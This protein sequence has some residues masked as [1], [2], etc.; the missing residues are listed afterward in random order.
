MAFG[1]KSVFNWIQKGPLLLHIASLEQS[2]VKFIFKCRRIT[3][4]MLETEEYPIAHAFILTVLKYQINFKDYFKGHY[5]RDHKIS[6]RS[7]QRLLSHKEPVKINMGI[8]EP[9][10]RLILTENSLP[11]PT[12]AFIIIWAGQENKIWLMPSCFG[13]FCSFGYHQPVSHF[14]P[15]HEGHFRSCRYSIL[16]LCHSKTVANQQLN[17]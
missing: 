1:L 17:N 4:G 3:K 15:N 6:D 7:M 9:A 8:S 10:Y 14:Y 2:E 13:Y 12:G 5:I 11:L 16:I